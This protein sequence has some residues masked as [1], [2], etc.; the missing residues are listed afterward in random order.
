M[1]DFLI[2]MDS[3]SPWM[4]TNQPSWTLV[5]SRMISSGI[6]PHKSLNRPKCSPEV[7]SFTLS[8][9]SQDRIHSNLMVTAALNPH[10]PDQSFLLCKYKVQQSMSPHLL[11]DHLIRK[12]LSMHSRNLVD[13]LCPEVLSFQHLLGC[14]AGLPQ[15]SGPQDFFQISEDGFA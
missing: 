9:S 8:P 2:G 13:C 15:G 5:L 1:L 3:S 7:Q 14:L 6:L 4:K 10:I 11:I 12:L